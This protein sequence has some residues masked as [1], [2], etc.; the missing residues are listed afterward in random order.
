MA[1]NPESLAS[2]YTAWPAKKRYSPYEGGVSPGTLEARGSTA[3]DLE[4]LTPL[5]FSGGKFQP[6]AGANNEAFTITADATPASAGDFTL[7]FE[8][9]TTA[10]IAFDADAADVLA[11]LVALSNVTADDVT[12]VASGAGVDLGDAGYILT[13][14]FVGAYEGVAVSLTAD[15]TGI[16]AGNDFALA[17]TVQGSNSGDISGFLVCPR[18]AVLHHE[19]LDTKIA[20]LRRGEVQYDDIALPTGEVQA[21]LDTALLNPELRKNGLD[22]RGLEGVA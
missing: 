13:V 15:Q 20:V 18:E 9:E 19:T 22:I 17:N 1:L 12:V 3:V 6:W 2:D 21:D 16:S 8:G 11:A 10:A 14:T 4:E 5:V 7:S